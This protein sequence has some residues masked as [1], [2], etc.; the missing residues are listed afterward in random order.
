MKKSNNVP[1]TGQIDDKIIYG[2]YTTLGQML[3]C[4]TEAAKKRYKRGN[5]E[6][7]Q[8]MR[9]IVETRKNGCF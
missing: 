5:P 9:T 7:I 4:N 2:D 1:Q 8:A 6:A 3:K